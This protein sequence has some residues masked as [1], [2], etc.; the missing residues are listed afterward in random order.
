MSCFTHHEDSR[1]RKSRRFLPWSTGMSTR[2]ARAVVPRKKMICCTRSPAR[3]RSGR[4][5]DNRFYESCP[6]TTP[7]TKG[8]GIGQAWF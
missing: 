8:F 6:P 5:T 7:R 2:K 1:E 4:G 3:G